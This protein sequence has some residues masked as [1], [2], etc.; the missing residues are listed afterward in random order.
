MATV[1]TAA[2]KTA[3]RKTAAPKVAESV[4]VPLDVVTDALSAPQTDAQTESV[5][6]VDPDVYVA[7]TALSEGF[8]SNGSIP[9][10]RLTPRALENLMELATEGNT[11]T[12]RAYWTRRLAQ[13]GV[14]VVAPVVSET[15]AVP[16]EPVSV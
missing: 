3:A 13:Y 14:K 16:A 9:L 4:S 7:P 10:D 11:E 12:A 5:T 15:P 6:P 8:E 1:T 2:K